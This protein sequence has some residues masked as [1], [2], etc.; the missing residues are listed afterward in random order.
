[1][2]TWYF[3]WERNIP[4]VPVMI[5]PY[6]SIDALFAAAPFLCRN[7][8]EPG[9]LAKRVVLAILIAGI[10]FLAVPL[11]FAFER[12]AVHGWLGTVFQALGAGDRPFNLFPSLHITF[13]VILADLY[14]R[15]TR[16]IVCAM[17]LAYFGLIGLSTLLTYQHHILH[18]VPWELGETSADVRSETA[19]VRLA[20]M[21]P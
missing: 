18:W 11:R 19:A 8:T 21:V 1:M 16:G 17:C 2:G 20:I 9:V 14:A 10:C 7:Q 6:V 13:C 12:P 5:L 15:R 4:F 3:E